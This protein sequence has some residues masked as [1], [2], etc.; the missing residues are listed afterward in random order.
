VGWGVLGV[1]V[2]AA[3]GSGGQKSRNKRK[4]EVESNF[5]QIL[6][7]ISVLRTNAHGTSTA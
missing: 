2:G 5:S 3:G 6:A 1:R 7:K 4:S